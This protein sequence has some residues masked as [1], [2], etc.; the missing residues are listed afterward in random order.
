[1]EKLDDNTNYAVFQRSFDKNGDHEN[2]G[3]SKF[4]TMK[5]AIAK[6]I[7][8]KFPTVIVVLSVVVAG[9]LLLI[10]VV[11][12]VTVWRRFHHNETE[13]SSMNSQH[14][15]T[16]E[17]VEMSASVNLAT[18]QSAYSNP[19]TDPSYYDNTNLPYYNE[20]TTERQAIYEAV[21][22]QVT[23]YDDV[24]PKQKDIYQE[25]DQGIH[26]QPLN[27]NREV[28]YEGFVKPTAGSAS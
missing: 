21:D 8:D 27:L 22:G 15:S 7:E 3:F 1:M 5:V 10:I 11:G 24:E 2:E 6:P 4:T 13:T 25:I 16:Q 18:S 14:C 28:N 9:L 19:S 12:A 26:Y 20:P 23:N 17:I